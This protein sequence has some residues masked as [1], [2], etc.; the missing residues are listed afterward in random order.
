V[1]LAGL[2]VLSTAEVEQ[3]H[4]AATHILENAGIHVEDERVLRLLGDAGASVDLAH[5]RC[6]IPERLVMAALET[7][8][9]RVPLFNRLGEQVATL[10]EGKPHPF[11]GHGMPFVLDLD[12][13]VRPAT[14]ADVC[15]LIR[16]V[17]ALPNLDVAAVPASPQDVPVSATFAHACDAVLN[18]SVKPLFV[19]IDRPQVATAIMDLARLATGVED[20]SAHPV[21]IAM[22]SLESPLRFPKQ[23]CDLLTTVA[24]AGVPMVIHTAPLSGATAPLTLAG[25][26]AMHNA[27][28]LAGIVIAQLVRPGTPIIYGGGWG[29][30]EMRA[31][32]RVVASPE[33]ALLRIA[34]AQLTRFY[35]L[36]RHTV[37]IYADCPSPDEQTG[38]EKMLT[39]MATMGA[40]FDLMSNSGELCTGML[41]SYEQVVLDNEMLGIIKRMLA[42]FAVTPETLALDMIERVGP[43][44]NFLTEDHTVAQLRSGEFWE[45]TVAF[46]GSMSSWVDAGRP[47]VLR[48]ARAQ[49]KHILATHRPPP[50]TDDVRREMARVV[51]TL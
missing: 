31:C 15:D 18:N 19:A 14:K 43:G 10:G 33:A 30:M 16:L 49:V 20:I 27:E 47:D 1:K 13:G 44:G 25:V 39:G 29:A 12:S 34:G 42:G 51:A 23:I 35:N 17:D 4:A 37:G 21:M 45:P 5:E 9:R 38:W 11:V 26:M 41:V 48:R 3:V 32:Q 50:L 24:S 40:G 28:V 22:V 46:S 36:P 2:E 6:K 7:T 8:P